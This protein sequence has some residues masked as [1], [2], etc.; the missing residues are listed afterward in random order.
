MRTLALLVVNSVYI[1]LIRGVA[2]AVNMPGSE[3]SSTE[4]QG[5]GRHWP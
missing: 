4:A 5:G 1:F 3:G 2:E